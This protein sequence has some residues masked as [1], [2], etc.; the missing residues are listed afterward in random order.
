[1]PHQWRHTWR[2]SANARSR[3]TQRHLMRPYGSRSSASRRTRSW[4][5][6]ASRRA[7]AWKSASTA[8]TWA[9]SRDRPPTQPPDD[10]RAPRA[11]VAQEHA[12]EKRYWEVVVPQLRAR[13]ADRAAAGKSNGLCINAAI[14]SEVRPNNCRRRSLAAGTEHIPATSERYWR[15]TA[16]GLRLVAMRCAA[17]RRQAV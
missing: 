3:R 15:M 6:F 12:L 13:H 1:M 10:V 11:V 9:A 17:R 4:R 8:N 14:G 2:P 16:Y 5:P 7:A